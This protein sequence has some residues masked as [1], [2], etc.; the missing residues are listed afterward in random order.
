MK[1]R[2]RISVSDDFAKIIKIGAIESNTGTIEFSTKIIEN[3][4]ILEDVI[5]ERKKKFR[6][7]PN[8]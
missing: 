5:N 6:F 8:F 1:Q 4:K 2:E 3:P 7:T